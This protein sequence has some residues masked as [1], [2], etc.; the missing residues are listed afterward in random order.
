MQTRLVLRGYLT[1][2]IH[3]YCMVDFKIEAFVGA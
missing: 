2:I 1:L 3:A